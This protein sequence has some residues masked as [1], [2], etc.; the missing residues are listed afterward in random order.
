M[1][2]CNLNFPM[3]VN[4]GLQLCIFLIISAISIE[5]NQ[6]SPVVR[7]PPPP[8]LIVSTAQQHTTFSY[9][10][11]NRILISK[12]PYQIIAYIPDEKGSINFQL[13]LKWSVKKMSSCL[14]RA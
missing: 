9:A 1:E 6:L 5:S 13:Y 2:K 12:T 3:C 7:N 8:I 4:S 14:S 11:P 10:I